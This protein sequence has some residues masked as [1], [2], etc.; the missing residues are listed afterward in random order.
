MQ[1]ILLF[2]LPIIF[3][4]ARKE[5]VEAL[6]S[7][8]E[9]D[10][11]T[12]LF[13]FYHLHSDTEFGN[14]ALDSAFSLINKHREEKIALTTIP[15]FHRID[16][17]SFLT[18]LTK[19]PEEKVP[20]LEKEQIEFIEKISS[21]LHHHQLK[22]HKAKNIKEVLALPSHQ[23]DLA[24]AIFLSQ[25]GDQ[26]DLVKSY[27]A[28]LDL[29]ALSIL[30]RLPKNP[31]KDQTI[32]QISHFIF[33]EMLFRFPPHSLWIKDI[34]TYTFLPSILD[35][36]HGVCLGVSILYLSLAQR[37]GIDL[38]ICTPPGHIYLSY[39]NEAGEEIN[40]ETTARGIHI[41]T[42]R[43][44]SIQT[45]EIE[46][47]ELKE[48]IGL[49]H[50]NAASVFWHGDR[51]EKAIDQ[52][53]AALKYMPKDV[54]TQTL[55]GFNCLLAGKEA[56]GRYYLGQIK[57]KKIAGSI[58]SNLCAED[59][60]NGD[61]GMEGIQAIYESVDETRES[62]IHK[63]KELMKIV[64]KHP[65]FRDGIFHIATTWLQLGRKKEALQVLEG[66]HKIDSN[67]PIV[68]YYLTYLNMERLKQEQASRHYKK[69][70]FLLAQEKHMPD[71]VKDMKKM[72]KMQALLD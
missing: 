50:I 63:Q 67:N 4:F 1:K 58:T 20:K 56:K 49:Y 15:L 38:T 35:S 5:E 48:V 61:V 55:L 12:K 21:H 18:M 34:D 70:C 51:Y 8:I 65:K 66:Y 44:L 13:A 69:L 33:Y 14:S 23:V 32:E 68:E 54:L 22:G 40:I 10:N 43:Y 24:R 7:Q 60:L 31:T 29:F 64:E 42:K 11:L 16:L 45:K 37:L 3:L 47:K 59:F 52:Y 25:Y 53:E 26:M 9:T 71:G 19:Q 57:G 28:S 2:L 36:R 41:P 6:Y 62:I 46:H 72:L 27:E 30:A 17:G 39:T